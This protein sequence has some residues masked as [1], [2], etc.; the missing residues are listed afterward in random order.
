MNNLDLQKLKGYFNKEKITSNKKLLVYLFFVGLSTIF[1]FLNALSKEYTTNINYPV[2]Y[3]NLPEDKVLTNELPKK[4]SLRVKA[5]GLYLLRYKLSTAFLSNPFDVNKYTNNRITGSSLNSYNLLTSSITARV[6]KELSTGIQLESISPDTIRFQFSPILEKKVPV[7]LNLKLNYEQQFMQGGIILP[8]F[9]SVLVKGPQSLLDSVF[10][11]KTELLEL[12][13]LKKTTEKE[14]DFNKIKGISFSPKKV[15]VNIPVERF[16]EA[17]KNV[18][19]KVDNLPDSVLLRLFPGDVKLSYFVGMNKYENI[20]EDHFDLRV[21]YLEATQGDGNKLKVELK[22]SP[23]FVSN[24]RFYPQTVTF[25]IEKR[26][27]VQ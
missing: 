4:L 19:I 15:K 2:Y 23:D 7:E 22:R 17:N 10:I 26:N 3:M 18:P 6:E 20:T 9:D 11:A 25:L 8:E 14:I 27:S 12:S 5:N 1:W 16:T 13:G 24:V 21:D